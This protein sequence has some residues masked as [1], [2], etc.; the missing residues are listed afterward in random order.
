MQAEVKLKKNQF[1]GVKG[2]STAHFL[3]SVMNEVARGLADDR[4]AVLLTLIDYAKAFNRLSF[5]HCLSAL[6]RLGASTPVLQLTATFLSNRV[7]TCKVGDS[8]SAP[9]EVTG[10]VP[11]GSI[12][13]VFL[14]NATTDDLEDAPEAPDSDTDPS[15]EEETAHLP[16]TS[17]SWWDTTAT[18]SYTHL[19]L[20][21][22]YSV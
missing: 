5:Q 15:L 9:R 10:G 18:V 20:P 8:W 16:P 13:G 12:L 22:I 21:T 17:D 1:G 7:M 6:A 2:C 4:A 3:I 14:F 19:T 11:Q